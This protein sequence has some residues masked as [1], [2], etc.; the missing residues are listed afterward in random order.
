MEDVPYRMGRDTYPS[1]P[2]RGTATQSKYVKPWQ[3]AEW[4]EQAVADGRNSE[5]L[6]IAMGRLRVR[7]QELEGAGERM[8]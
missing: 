1:I 2:L 8:H 3:W 6:Q 7:T 4:A 5:R